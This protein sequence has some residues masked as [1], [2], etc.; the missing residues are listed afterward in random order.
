MALSR[1]QWETISSSIMIMVTVKVFGS[2]AMI[3]ILH[4]VRRCTQNNDLYSVAP[5]ILLL[6]EILS[7]Q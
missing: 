4:Y 7:S 5:F 3:L 1:Q 6:L 2:R